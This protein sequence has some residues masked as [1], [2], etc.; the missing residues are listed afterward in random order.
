MTP[1]VHVYT[2]ARNEAKLMPYFLRHYS[3]FADKLIV[4]DEQSD[5]GTRELVKSCPKAELREW[6]H[7]G[8][9]DEKFLAAINECRDMEGPAE[10]RIWADVD[11][12]LYHPE[13]LSMLGSVRLDLLG[14]IG[15]ALIS[16]NGLLVDD[17]RQLYEQVPTGIPQSNYDKF[18][19]HRFWLPV[20][21]AIGRHTYGKEWPQTLGRRG[22]IPDLK[23]FHCHHIG[24]VEHT[25][26]VNQRNYD[27]AV[28]KRYAWNYAPEHD[29]PEQ[30]GTV[31]W[32]RD[33]IENGKLKEVWP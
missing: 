14:A 15:Y 23:L 1:R 21:H 4:Y 10:W 24:G 27:R 22:S 9:D 31:A 3:T 5:D 26:E 17:G 25:K 13:M 6:P 20:K 19:L 11:E 29:K 12:L 28:D 33:A 30:V 16:P 18:I 2:I 32:V 8:L 7:V